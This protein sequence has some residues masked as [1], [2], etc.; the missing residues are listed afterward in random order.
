[1]VAAMT[2][3]AESSTVSV[4]SLRERATATATALVRLVVRR[5][6]KVTLWQ[7]V[8]GLAIFGYVWY[9]TKTSLEIH[10]GL[11]TSAYDF[12][13]YDQ[14]VWLLSRLKAPFVTLMG[15][16]L[17]GDH[18]SFI[19]LFLVPV[20]WV[21][22]TA[23]ALLFTQSAALGAGAI[24]IFLYA[25]QRLG[26]EAIATLLG[27]AYLLHP[28][29]GWTNFE[30]FHP[31]SFLGVFIGFAIYFAINERWR[32]YAVFV[33][34]ALLVKE[35]VSLIV[36]PLGVWV[37]F[38][39]IGPWGWPRSCLAWATPFLPRLSLSAHRPGCR[40]SIR[41]GFPLGVQPDSLRGRSSDRGSYSTI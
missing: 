26:S 31:D 20:Y 38:R 22:P 32:P 41:G 4:R 29:V 6:R 5:A 9:F 34:L 18:T 35:D 7:A 21:F 13:L 37:A 14:G 23:G 2:S 1:M 8:L 11:G 16:N 15:R 24:P 10:H 30:Q 25:R 40:L 39:R 36:V 17:F 28:I 12:G 19:M 33:V 27:V 3:T